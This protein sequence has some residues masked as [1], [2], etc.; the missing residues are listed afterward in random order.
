MLGGGLG[1]DGS[2]TA[3][4]VARARAAAQL[5]RQRADLAVIVSG[6]HGDGP[7]PPRTEAAVMAEAIEKTGIAPERIFREERSRETLG[8]AVETA[9]Q[10]L[11]RISPRPLYV[12][13]SPF[14]LERALVVFRTVLGFAW[15]VQAVSAEETDDD[16]AKA[17]AE[18]RY[19][20]ETFAFFKGLEPGDLSGIEKRY[21]Q[22]QA[23]SEWMK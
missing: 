1:A 17:N 19:L 7:A 16:L 2:P 13:T 3:S 23:A 14:H 10:F 18:T 12:V 20:Q 8:N 5:A 4:T 9:T 15:Q 21:R 6:S 22:R 11:A